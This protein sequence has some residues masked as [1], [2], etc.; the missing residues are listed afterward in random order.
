MSA[1]TA[2]TL[3]DFSDLRDLPEFP[4]IPSSR[5]GMLRR[6]RQVQ[7]WVNR[8]QAHYFEA[9]AHFTRTAEEPAT[10]PHEVALA[11]AI[12][13]QA[14]HQQVELAQALTTRLPHT[15]EAMQRGEID[16]YKAAKILEPT[17]ILTDDEARQVDA[18]MST[19]LAGKD[20][21]GLRRSTNRA[22]A[23]ID[24]EGYAGRCRARRVRR[25][26]ELI[27]LDDGM[28]QLS[29]DLPVEIGVAAYQ[30]IDREARRR[31]ARDKT[32]TLE[33]HRADVYA[34]LLLTEQR[35]GVTTPRA[36]VFVYMDV[37]TWLGLNEDVAELGGQGV[38]PAWL[39]RQ[40]AYSD[41]ATVRRVITDPDTG[42]IVSV[43]RNAY[44][45]PAG[46]A[47]L[48]RVRDRECRL[49]GCYRPSQ[50]SD[51][52]H[53]EQWYAHDGETADQNLV[54]LCRT[55][56]G[57]K[58]RLGW[59]FHIDKKTGRLT[60]ITPTG[61]HHTSDPPPLHEPRTPDTDESAIDKSIADTSTVDDTATETLAGRQTVTGDRYTESTPRQSEAHPDPSEPPPF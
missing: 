39:A 31:R 10:V 44:R 9:L 54:A 41:N 60:V 56:H 34:E 29:G 37:L 20:P 2:P 33:Q 58:H 19:R 21:G 1:P 46:L 16:G 11:L 53:S 40:I 51:I 52:D 3:P 35:G 55:H 27:P 43:G 28:V 4:G 5:P 24:P 36:E 49:P 15:L 26:V 38:I 14:A 8:L 50:A 45:P 42:Q 7:A 57:L 22:V 30:R 59:G 61:D 17:T 48:I 6:M 25:K 13:K 47:R 23:R 32:R 18:V 12:G